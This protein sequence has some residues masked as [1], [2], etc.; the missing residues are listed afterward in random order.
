MAKQ[1]MTGL[2]QFE[3]ERCPALTIGCISVLTDVE[4]TDF[5]YSRDGSKCRAP[6]PRKSYR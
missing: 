2:T 1:Q 5:R 6:K 4:S 3:T